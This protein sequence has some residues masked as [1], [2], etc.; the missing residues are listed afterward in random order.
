MTSQTRPLEEILSE[1]GVTPKDVTVY[2]TLLQE[3]PGSVRQLATLTG[4]NR[5]TVYDALK[6][7]QELELVN[8]YNRETKQFFVAAP[9]ARLQEL[10]QLRATEL[11]KASRELTHVVAELEALYVAGTR[12]PVARMYEGSEGIRSILEDVL[13]TM[14]TAP[15]QEYY[16]YSSSSVR[17]AGLYDAFQDYTQKRIDAGV[18]VKVISIGKDSKTVGLDERRSIPGLESTPTYTLIYN[19]KV[20]NVFLDKHGELL[21]LIIE[22]QG[23]YETQKTLFL[24]LWERLVS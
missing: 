16:V 3:G 1:L 9:P 10:A 24:S 2:L 22:N 21:G 11:S 19:G 18:S 8:F 14:R 13:E 23:I 4:V 20:A 15:D 7:L 6:H 12:Q 17:E 5:G